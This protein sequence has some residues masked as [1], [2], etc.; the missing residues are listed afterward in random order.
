METEKRHR[1]NRALAILVIGLAGLYFLMYLYHGISIVIFPFNWEWGEGN[2]YYLACRLSEGQPIY[3]SLDDY[4]FFFVAQPP[5]YYAMAAALMPLLGKTLLA[6]RLLSFVASLLIGFLIYGVVKGETRNTYLGAVCALLFFASNFVYEWA[7]YFW[8]NMP[9]VLF[10]LIGVFVVHKYKD[11]PKIYLAIIPLVLSLY[12]KPYIGVVAIISVVIFLLLINRKVAVKMALALF[13]C[14]GAIFLFLNILTDGEF[15]RHMFLYLGGFPTNYL[16]IL[17]CSFRFLGLHAVLLGF[18]AT[19][20]LVSIRRRR[21]SVW[22]IYL[23]VSLAVT[24]YVVR[25]A[26]T[27]SYYYFEATAIVCIL[28]GLCLG[29]LLAG[30]K[31]ALKA[32]GVTI[33]LCLLVMQLVL[34]I[35]CPPNFDP[36]ADFTRGGQTPTAAHFRVMEEVSQYVQATPGKVY[37]QELAFAVQNNKEPWIDVL[38]MCL[39]YHNPKMKAA[40]ERFRVDIENKEFSLIVISGYFLPSE[41]AQAIAENYDLMKEIPSNCN[42]LPYRFYVPKA[43]P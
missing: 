3:M 43:S 12:T 39:G 40:L 2:L 32:K 9:A 37:I 33:L 19:Y 13:I 11:S 15:F 38:G 6:G 20:L 35:H 8:A 16:T 1:L 23:L 17:S 31:P 26:G 21:L 22:G 42:P 28:T 10:S 41:F 5:L 24:T 34:F 25:Q 7:G 18:A 36:Y 14:C 29:E 4:P 30:L 27:G